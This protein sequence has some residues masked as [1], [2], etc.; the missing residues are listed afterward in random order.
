MAEVI[1]KCINDAENN[2]KEKDFI[3]KYNKQQHH[4]LCKAK[5]SLFMDRLSTWI[6]DKVLSENFLKRMESKM[7]EKKRVRQQKV[8]RIQGLTQLLS[9]ELKQYY[10][11]QAQDLLSQQMQEFRISIKADQGL[12]GG[13]EVF[14]K[15]NAKFSEYVNDLQEVH[16]KM[17]QRFVNLQSK[18]G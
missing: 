17:R 18:Y 12:K 8:K 1:K 7:S 2:F 4:Q 16:D 14:S 3:Q 9:S 11:E 13:H 6:D 5:L 10:V 15:N